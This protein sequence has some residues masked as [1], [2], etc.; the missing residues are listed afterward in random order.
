MPIELTPV[1]YGP[2]AS[3]ALHAAVVAAKAGDPLAPVTV[4]VPT[5]YVGVAARRLLGSGALGRVTPNGDGVAGITFLTGFRLAELIGAPKLAAA[6]RRPVS[7]PVLAAGVRAVLADA[8][9][10]FRPV[11][12]HPATE[13]ALV[14]AHR[15]LSN[16]DD[17]ALDALARSGPRAA[18][19]VRISRRVRASLAPEWYDERDLMDAATAEVA[20]GV[21]LLAD[22]GAVVVHLPQELSTPAAALL[23][24]LATRVPVTV[25]AGTT[26]DARADAAVRAAMA[27]LDLALPE[28]D[29]SADDSTATRVVSTSD[30]DDEVR[31]MVRLVVDAARAGVPLERMAVLYGAPEP[32]A[33]LVHEHL[34]AAGI[35]H[36]GAAVR[37]LADSALGRGLLG[38]LA[39]PDRDF[40]RHDVMRLLASTPVYRQGRDV[41]SASWERISRAA[42]IV[43]GPEHWQQR[44]DRYA[45]MVEAELAAERAVTDRDPR[46]QRY[47]RRLADTRDLQDFVATL[48]RDL[49]VDPAASWRDLAGWAERLVRD[50]LAP[51]SRRASW[52]EAEQLAG[53]KIDAALTRL[54]GLDAVE[55]SPGVDVFRRTLELELDADLGRVGRFGDGLLMGHV[56]LGLGLDLDRVFVCGLAEGL[57]P[58]RV[59]D[60]SLLPDADRRAT[61][62]ALPLRA[63]RVHDDH[64]RLLAALASAAHERVLLFPR[65]DLRR[66]TERVPSRFLPECV[67]YLPDDRLPPDLGELHADRYAP[68]PSFAAGLARVEFPATEQEHRL[69][70]LLDHARDGGAVNDH[71]LARVDVALAR[72]VGT[73][74]ARAS[75]AFTRFDGNLASHAVP[76]IA[77]GE[78]V[79]SPTRLQTYAYNPH[80]YF[81]DYVLRV[82]IPE[83]PEERYEV[84]PLD[85]GS[86]VHETLDAFL[87]EVLDRPEGAPAP[88]TAWAEADRD[89]LR[90]IAESRFVAYEAQGRTGRRLFWHRDRRRILAELDRFLTEDSGVRAG[91][92]MRPI[93]TELRFGFPD[94][95]PAVDIGLSDG[96][97][98]RF[99]GAADRVD[100]TEGG[101]L[102]VL[103][104]KTGWP[105]RIEPDD[106]TAGGTM[107]QLPV[108]AHAAR[109]SFGTSDTPVGA[110]YWYVSTRGGFRWAEL[111]LT[112]AVDARVD[113]VLRAIA[114]GIDEGVFPC[115]VDPPSTWGR[116]SRSYL[117]PDARGTRD[118]YREWLRKRTE[119]ELR[120]YVTLAEP[121][122]L[123]D[124]DG[125]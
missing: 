16:V 94:S 93:A 91:S 74:L 45:G 9:G 122:A 63:A 86:L 65:G 42:E 36:N 102:W 50:H 27:R 100:T 79:V 104:Y 23:R 75:R 118:R 84:T 18:D 97:S 21:P 105:K 106:P 17:A 113:E 109:A 35:A 96:R 116:R 1:P 30:P 73:V 56:A 26:G 13:A 3:R 47:E 68:V 55:S 25:V 53:E 101:T 114:D 71:E 121:Q 48:A 8:P 112:D 72:G 67:E 95:A 111:V 125:T 32:Y 60:D 120:G 4:I 24:A 33:R 51:E 61:D 83:L 39:L 85:R 58:T 15:E 64:R 5:N 123:D 90:E 10:R 14:A 98:L 82:E 115:R 46:P 62:G 19:V 54:A 57:F 66:T 117:D 6:H 37:T 124:G 88:D 59:H 44:L 29:A 22:L 103:D 49:R 80:D 110:A 20:A 2:E 81:L 11:A 70:T 43:R 99:R 78:V 69:R 107:L 89:R 34:T 12:E 38:L 40:Q 108:Y 76:H 31:A 52:P 77:D 41:P 7:M 92:G 28:A 119:P 87:A